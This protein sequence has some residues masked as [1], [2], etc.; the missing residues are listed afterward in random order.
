MDFSLFW[1]WISEYRIV[2]MLI[3]IGFLSHMQP[4]SWEKR[5]QSFLV[6]LPLPLQSLLMAFIIWILFQARS[7]DIQPFI[8][9]QF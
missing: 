1:L 4:D 9:F 6:K 3:L 5:Y 8:Y 7:A 2:A